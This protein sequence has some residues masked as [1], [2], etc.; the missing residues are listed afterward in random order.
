VDGLSLATGAAQED[1][2]EFTVTL[3][4]FKSYRVYIYIVLY[5]LMFVLLLYCVTVALSSATI[6]ARYQMLQYLV[7]V[8][9]LFQIKA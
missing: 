9:F 6:K 7:P 2:R 1:W 8:G 5:F 3:I 4:C